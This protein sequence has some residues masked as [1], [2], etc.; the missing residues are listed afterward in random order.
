MKKVFFFVIVFLLILLTGGSMFFVHFA[1]A[2]KKYN[3][4]YSADAQFKKDYPVVKAWADSMTDVHAL[5]DT[6]ITDHTGRYKLHALYARNN[7]NSRWT[8]ICIH[9]YTSDAYQMLPIGYMYYKMG[10]NILLPDL[11][12]HGKS[13]GN[14]IQMGW[15]DR[16]DVLKWIFAAHRAFGRGSDNMVVHGVSMGAATA[17][18]VSGEKLPVY[19]KDFVED[20]GFTS[21]WDIF[22]YRLDHQFHLPDFPFLYTSNL[23]CKFDYGWNFKEASPLKQVAKCTRPMLFIHSDVDTSVPTWMV[24]P[25][26]AAKKGRKVLWV[27]HGSEHAKAYHDHPVLYTEKVKTFLFGKRGC[28]P[29]RKQ[30]VG[31]L[32]ARTPGQMQK[33]C[34]ACC[35]GKQGHI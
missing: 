21:V 5:R 32:A 23:I 34:Y 11:Y 1:L 2:S 31:N 13:G 22:S 30:G 3:D 35:S 20:S 24:F 16:L 17:M 25:L 12:G 18:C 9:G 4:P 14:D 29:L 27:L 8:A 10:F 33:V 28:T 15:K 6:F 7:V 26:Y 19:V